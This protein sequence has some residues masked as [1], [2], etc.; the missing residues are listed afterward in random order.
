M[1]KDGQSPLYKQFCLP[2]HSAADMRV[3]I[4]EKIYH[5]SENPVNTR[6]HRRLGE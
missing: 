5:S 2:G 3:Q 4:F 1:I 6:I